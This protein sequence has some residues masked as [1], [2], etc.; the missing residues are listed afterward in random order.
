MDLSTVSHQSPGYMCVE[1]GGDFVSTNFIEDVRSTKV[2]AVLEDIAL[3]RGC[4]MRTVTMNGFSNSCQGNIN[5]AKNLPSAPTQAHSRDLHALVNGDPNTSFDVRLSHAGRTGEAQTAQPGRPERL[6]SQSSA[7]SL[8]SSSASASE[9]SISFSDQETVCADDLR[10]RPD[11][12]SRVRQQGS[13]SSSEQQDPSE[14]PGDDERYQPEDDELFHPDDD[15]DGE[16]E[17][18]LPAFTG[19]DMRH[20]EVNITSTNEVVFG[21]KEVYNISS[22]L[23]EAVPNIN[24]MSPKAETPGGGAQAS[25]SRG[26]VG[27]VDAR[28]RP[29]HLNIDKAQH[30]AQAAIPMMCRPHSPVIKSQST[31][32]PVSSYGLTSPVMSAHQ[33]SMAA[34]MG[35]Q[36]GAG[37]LNIPLPSPMLSPTGSQLSMSHPLASAM[38]SPASR[39]NLPTVAT[40]TSQVNI[41]DPD[42]VVVGTQVVIRCNEPHEHRH[43]E[44][45]VANIDSTLAEVREKLATVYRTQTKTSLLPWLKGHQAIPM[46]EFYTNSR[47]LA[48]DKQGKQTSQAVDLVKD[49]INEEETKFLVEGEPGMGKTLLA[50]KMAIDWANEKSLQQIKFVFLIFLRDFKGSLEQYI[51]EELLPSGFD[52]KFKKVWEY[53]K[54]NEEQV[55]FIL[56]GYDELNKNDEGEIQNLLRY[57][58]FQKSKVVVTSRPDV[59]KTIFQRTIVKGFSE[60]QMMEFIGKYFRLSNEEECGRMLKQIIERDY[61][62][63]KLAKRPLFCVLLCMLY[64]SERSV[65]K[66]P[67]KLSDMMFKIMLCLIKW[68]NNKVGGTDGSAGSADGN[69]EAFPPEYQ[70]KFLSFGKL[71]MEALKTDK[72]RFSEK[73]IENY[74]LLVPLG[75]LSSDSENH[76][77]G[78][79]K[80]YKPVH[81]IFLEY[82]AGLYMADTI[83]RDRREHKDFTTIYRHE[84]VLK[85]MVGVLGKRAHLALEGKRQQDFR[86]MK[87]QEILM[88]LREAGTTPDNCRAVARLLDRDYH[89]VYTSEVDFEGWSSILDQ[90]FHM[91]KNLELV[92]RIKSNNPDQESSF[93][94]ASPELYRQFF[95]ALRR[96]KSIS[97]IR[98]RAT[99]DGEPFSETKIKLF[100]SHF[101]EALEKENLK[102][103]EIKELNMN[104]LNGKVSSSLVQA[105]AEATCNSGRKALEALEV[106]RLDMFLDDDALHN[107][108]D[109][110]RNDSP[111]LKELQLTGLV[112][113]RQGFKSL[114]ELLKKNKNLHKLHLSMNRAQLQH[115]TSVF[116]SRDYTPT[117]MKMDLIRMSTYAN[118]KS[119]DAFNQ[120]VQESQEGC[121]LPDPTKELCYLFNDPLKTGVKFIHGAKGFCFVRDQDVRLPLPLCMGRGHQSIFHDLFSALPETNVQKLTLADPCLYLTKADLVCLGDAIRKTKHLNSLNLQGLYKVECYMPVL[122]GLGQS[123]S[124]T[125]VK[126]DSRHVVLSDTAFF[127]AC[128]ALRNNTTLKTLSLARWAFNIQDKTLAARYFTDL[129]SSW[130]VQDLNLDHCSIDIGQ[131]LQP[132]FLPPPILIPVMGPVQSWSS[133][134][135]LR[136][137]NVKLMEP[138][139]F[140]RSG[141]LLLPVLRS[142][143][144]LTHLDLSVSQANAT[145]LDDKTT[146]KFFQLLGTYFKKLQELSLGS[147]EFKFEHYEETCKAVGQHVRSCTEL[148]KLNLDEA[149]EVRSGLSP[150]PCRMTFLH[151]LVHHLPRLSELSLCKYRID[152]ME[153]DRDTAQRLGTCFH[154]H[155]NTTTK[156]ELKFFG[157]YPEVQAVLEK[158]LRKV[159]Y[160][161]E[162]SQGSPLITFTVKKKG[163]FSP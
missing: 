47:I 10:R 92:W 13:F 126:L 125:T 9:R 98:V 120:T 20:A 162:I 68:N 113:G 23:T 107:L 76:V 1:N 102:E 36:Q 78:R 18:G 93:N 33:I 44:P 28:G 152:E 22:P 88:L 58:D 25:D 8:R 124:L 45:H 79:K 132:A 91:L 15:D 142:C 155:W 101:K 50:L 49:L 103:L 94:E 17:A 48:V 29:L 5:G 82:L 51:K 39:I 67:E 135:M 136:L 26:G 63:R 138:L 90:K 143:P 115:D 146:C 96:N 46:N 72:T 157:L 111:K 105:V 62:Y 2:P 133:I 53:C 40:P 154:D 59:L 30:A 24:V 21:T 81:K 150:L 4:D 89:R 54:N 122:L 80:F 106:L 161:V 27:R 128:T 156:F 14:P 100:F 141:H 134:N 56:D 38:A 119:Q 130:K 123:P 71:C 110:L 32:I 95:S 139:G 11:G 129:L 6:P 34:A 140:L 52:E 97:M 43:V 108:C 153:L 65:A 37:V 66:L 109:R 118:R 19:V 87:D 31:P 74:S 159:N 84:H 163:F 86:H 69:I 12:D 148:K 16:D 131:S 112:H 145:S 137:A 99:Q 160:S 144:N 117:H 41:S 83:E 64:D 114:V 104:V 151:N 85:F 116:M 158:S 42:N 149:S 70:E 73:Q 55:L 57:R 60:E 147:W 127:L 77:Y 35:V 75:F 121:T 61:K 3:P 7:S